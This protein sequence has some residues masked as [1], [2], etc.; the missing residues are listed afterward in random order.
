MSRNR[1]LLL[2]AALVL[3]LLLA[4]ARSFGGDFLWDD[5]L[6]ITENPTIVGPLGLKEIWTT[7][8]ANYFPLVLTHL[9]LVHAVAGLEPVA[10]H[11]VTFTC[12]GIAALLLWQVLRRLGVPG[13]WLGAALWALHPVQV[14]SVAWICE[15]KN[16]QSAVFFLGAVWFW[17][18]WLEPAPAGSAP[19]SDTTRRDYALALLCG[20]A[21]L[22]SK[23]S[24]VMLPVALAL[25]AWWRLRRIDWRSAR[26]LVPFLALSALASGWTIWEQ[27]VNSGAQGAEW[28]QTLPERLVI[29][30][31]AVWF[32]FGK[33]LWPD[34]LIFIYPR[35]EI[36]ATPLAFLPGLAVLATVVL[37]WRW[38]GAAGRATLFT[39]LYFGALLFPILGFFNVFFFRY[40]FVGDHFQYLAS[41]GPLALLA[42][43]IVALPRVAR[44]VVAGVVLGVFALLTWKHT[45]VFQTMEGLWRHTVAL[46]PECRMAWLNLGDTHS[47]RQRHAEAIAAYRAALRVA[48]NDAE[49]H[50]D[51]GCELVLTGAPAEA[52]AHLE[53]A[54]A[55]KPHVAS[56]HSNLGNALRAVG[57]R[58]EAIAAYERALQLD[59]DSADGHANLGAEFAETG[60]LDE[61]LPHLETAVHLRPGN[62]TAREHLARAYLIVRRPADAV[63]HF[64]AAAR[65]AP[66]AA[67]PAMGLGMALSQL[68]RWSE[69]IGPLRRA[70]E[71]D[72]R[73]AEA[74]ARLALA[75][76]KCDRNPEAVAAF[77]T[78]LRLSPNNAEFHFNLGVL[79]HAMGRTGD[80]ADHLTR[81]AQLRDGAR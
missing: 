62:S 13:A 38:R 43:G 3:L 67:G 73:N 48:P 46:H 26:A 32:Y 76:A 28:S 77:E 80:A 35:W 11:V 7:A 69:A 12:H 50:N 21:A 58:R 24:T 78:A 23:P 60:R 1:S 66:E 74:H 71:L 75:L 2:A 65:L 22:L 5:N 30:G 68:E 19:P 51:L 52:V 29:A 17:L 10:Y 81:A 45:A 72:P 14:E 18:R 47:R 59:P 44:G 9:W 49:G 41:M 79:L 36:Q 64:A 70:A 20:F 27:R 40:S 33:L 16:T 63:T 37:V 4:Y 34:R 57:R 53:R 15:L 56:H 8:R 39:A 55:L 61:A 25:C 42:A 31:R 6:H 54:V